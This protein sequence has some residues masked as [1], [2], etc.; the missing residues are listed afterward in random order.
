MFIAE[1]HMRTLKL[2]CKAWDVYFLIP[3][4]DMSEDY[5]QIQI[6]SERKSFPIE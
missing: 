1:L 4:G 3:V 6:N 5:L 2:L